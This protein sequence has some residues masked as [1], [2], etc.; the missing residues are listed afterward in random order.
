MS[1]VFKKTEKDLFLL[2]NVFTLKNTIFLQK[3]SFNLFWLHC[4]H[5]ESSNSPHPPVQAAPPP[6]HPMCMAALASTIVQ[7]KALHILRSLGAF[8]G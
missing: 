1:K 4:Q 2:L 3:I 5:Y 8:T 6:P 7:Q